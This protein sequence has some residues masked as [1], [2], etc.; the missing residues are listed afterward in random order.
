MIKNREHYQLTE[1][2]AE[3]EED[4]KVTNEDSTTNCKK[5]RMQRQR[6]N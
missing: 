4:E 3:G 5:L 1:N 6:K 2:R